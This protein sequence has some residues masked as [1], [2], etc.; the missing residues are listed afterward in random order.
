MQSPIQ[1]VLIGAPGSGK[2]T[3]ASLLSRHYGIPQI[4]TGELLRQAIKNQLPLGLEAQAAMD[5]G[6][7]VS[8]AIVMGIIRDRLSQ[9]DTR[10][11]FLL[12]GFP[13]NL[14]QAQ[15]LE[16]LLNT[17]GRPL[18]V[19]IRFRV[20]T[21]YLIQRLSGRLTCPQCGAVYNRYTSPPRFDDQCD[22]CGTLLRHRSDDNEETIINRLRVYEAQTEPLIG[23]YQSRGLLAEINGDGTIQGIFRQIRQV[24]NERRHRSV[25]RRK[26]GPKT[27]RVKP[28]AGERPSRKKPALGKAKP[29]SRKSPAGRTA[30]GK[31]KRKKLR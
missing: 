24:I 1:I 25:A 13:R 12:D 7:L 23:F 3:Q 8:D 29:K 10:S 14:E 11:G 31:A 21:E 5:Q 20:D 17:L 18:T 22:N 9:A 2:G 16:S 28:P 15:T 19:T 26:S 6:L 4:S 27:P 30:S